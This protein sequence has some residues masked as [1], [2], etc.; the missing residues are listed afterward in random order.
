MS[1]S[2]TVLADNPIRYYRLGETSGT[3]ATDVGSQAQN[4]TLNGGITLAQTDV[5]VGDSDTAELF[6]GSSGYIS[7]PT[8]SLP[9]GASAVSLECWLKFSALPGTG[10]YGIAL[11]IGSNV[12]NESLDIYYGDFS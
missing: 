1:Y 2:S 9:T 7:L 5:L 10:T 4:G 3:V 11:T 12:A 8:A 6:D